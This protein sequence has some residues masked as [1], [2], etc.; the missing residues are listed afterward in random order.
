MN[1]GP[2]IVMSTVTRDRKTGIINCSYHRMEIKS[3]EP[4]TGLLPPDAALLW[5]EN[6]TGYEETNL[7][8]V[9]WRRSRSKPSG[10][11]HGCVLL[12]DRSIRGGRV[13]KWVAG[14]LGENLSV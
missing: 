3:A 2:Y 4:P 10:L 1:G 13:P 6:P 8:M 7:R 5:K 9:P 12:L 14:N 11:Q